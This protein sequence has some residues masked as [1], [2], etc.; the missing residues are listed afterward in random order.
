MTG[1]QDEKAYDKR[2]L[3]LGAICIPLIIVS[4]DGTILNVALPTIATALHTTSAQLVWINAA[5]IIIFGST[6]LL[7][8][9]LGDKYGRKW[10]LL[11]GM[12]IFGLGSVGAGLSS[13]PLTLIFMRGFMG[14]GGGLL[15]PATLSIITNIFPDS[16]RQKA[17]G[18]WAG[19]SG[20]GV[21]V[22]PLAGGAILTYFHWSWVFFVNVPIVIAG[23]IAIALLVPHSKASD[24][25]PLDLK[26]ALISF[27]AL[28]SLFYGIIQGPEIGWSNVSVIFSFIL[29]V[30][31]LYLFV[32]Y[33]KRV[34]HPILD[35]NFFKIPEFSSGVISIAISFFALFGLIYMLTQFLQFVENYTPFR[36][37][38]AL[39]PFALVLLY[40]S[41]K[42]PILVKKFTRK[43]V[44]ISGFII[45]AAGL[46]IFGFVKT[47]T[48]YI[49]VLIALV[50][51]S[52]GMTMIQVPAS[53]SIMGS[54]PRDRAGQGSATNAAIRQIG[55]SFGIAI[56]GTIS[57]SVYYIQLSA[58]TAIQNLPS[59]LANS[60]LLGIPR[61]INIGQELG[62]SGNAL[63]QAAS[64]AF[65]NGMDI[66]LIITAFIALIGAYTAYRY[67][68]NKN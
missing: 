43:K 9:S 18:T 29:A 56:I 47:S 68:P 1:S 13:N 2:W 14:V 57:Q 60:A 46:F 67:L 62:D 61:A 52:L 48:T 26:G 31:L 23:L 20:I 28:L 17:I 55:S 6:I 5:Y 38:L 11:L 34:K 24:A 50:F 25:P 54:I 12:I 10:T 19:M 27:V 42:I 49:T 3:A 64:N 21:A 4:I 30:I 66:S 36:A 63:I 58:S 65:V 32:W 41:P 15:M 51:V 33:E 44:V 35:I 8:G 22:G 40:G 39:F 16:E 37:G 7:G 59:D 53:D 45:M